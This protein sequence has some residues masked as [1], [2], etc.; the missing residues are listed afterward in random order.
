MQGCLTAPCAC[1]LSFAHFPS[2]LPLVACSGDL[3]KLKGFVEEDPDCVNKPD[4]SGYYPL[5]VRWGQTVTD[6]P[7]CVTSYALAFKEVAHF[8]Y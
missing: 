3:E 1:E 6:Q 8:N 2:L 4:E 7:D 5:Q